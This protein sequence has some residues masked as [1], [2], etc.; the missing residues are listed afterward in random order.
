MGILVQREFTVAADDRAEF[1]AIAYG[2][3]HQPQQYGG[4]KHRGN[5]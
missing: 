3:K 2:P 1:E 4:A 5:A